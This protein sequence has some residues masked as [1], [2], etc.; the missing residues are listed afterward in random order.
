MVATVG[1]H[2]SASTWVFNIVRE[3][4]I[5]ERGECEVLSA[6][7]DETERLPDAAALAGKCLVLKSHHGSAGLDDWLAAHNA[8]FVLSLRDPRDAAVSMSQRFKAPLA[9]AAGWVAN[10]CDRLIRLAGAGRPLLFYEDRFFEDRTVPRRLAVSLGLSLPP[11]AIDALF[12]RYRADSVRALL[13]GIPG[14][15]PE[16]RGAVAGAMLDH[17]TQYLTV[18]LG[19]G[20]SGKWR[21]LPP[22]VAE[23]LTQ[24]YA[25]FLDRFGYSRRPFPARQAAL[26]P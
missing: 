6:Y 22:P 18:H 10:D 24:R 20:R 19:D 26:D 16:R 8:A 2:G 15:P 1:L 21:E 25:G 7:A 4:L 13:A 12:D 9:A 17:V 14:L 11:P 5:A 23:A 3:L